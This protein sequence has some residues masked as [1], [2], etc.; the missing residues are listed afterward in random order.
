MLL[1]TYLSEVDGEDGVRSAAHIVHLGG[2][3]DSTGDNT[4]TVTGH[5]YG[6]L[7]RAL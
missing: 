5:V 1:C 6:V 4:S 3:S 7:C 2:G